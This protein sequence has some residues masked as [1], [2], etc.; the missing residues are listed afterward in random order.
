MK[1]VLLFILPILIIVA[2]GFTAFGVAQVRFYEERLMDDLQRKART[3]DESIEFSVKRI[4]LDNDLKAARHLTESFQR[5]ERLQGCV[6]YNKDGEIIAI[7]QR[8]SDWKE[9]EKP[10]LKEIIDNKSPR[11]ALEKFKEYS[12]YSYILPVLDDEKNLIGL[13]EVIYDT[14]YVFTVLTQL[15]KRISVTLIA[16]LVLIVLTMLLIQRQIF[17]VPVKRL[18]EWFHHFQRGETST[19]PP[20]KEK[21]A[22]GKLVSEV[23][24]VALSLRIAR[25]IVTDRAS[26]RI[27]EVM[28]GDKLRILSRRSSE[29]ALF[30]V[31]IEALCTSW[32]KRNGGRNSGRQAES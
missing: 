11:G 2:V 3:V 23:E 7:T 20:I 15:W 8:L 31:S 19:I 1:R 28:D 18:T 22:L 17:I 13:S 29:N 21:G 24:Q 14:S 30:V 32:M 25:K 26:A 27:D 12:V 6:I 9:K 16:L 5:R 10:Y 4:L